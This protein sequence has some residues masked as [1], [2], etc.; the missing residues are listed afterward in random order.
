MIIADGVLFSLGIRS[1]IVTEFNQKV[2]TPN[3]R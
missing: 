3:G 1:G 2:F